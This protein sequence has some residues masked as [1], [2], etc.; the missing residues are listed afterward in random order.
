[1]RKGGGMW[2]L[3]AL[4]AG[5]LAAANS[6]HAAEF[7]DVV[8]LLISS[9]P[10]RG[11]IELVAHLETQGHWQFANR[12]GERF[13][14]S[15]SQEVRR[16]IKA[17][18]PQSDAEVLK[19]AIT[20]TS[21]AVTF[22]GKSLADLPDGA[23]LRAHVDGRTYAL[24]QR[25]NAEPLLQV[26]PAVSLVASDARA[27]SAALWHLNR[28]LP[29]NVMRVVG[30]EPGGP[31]ILSSSPR[32]DP[33]TKQTLVDLLDPG[34]LVPGLAGARGQFVVAKGRVR[35]D[36]LT[37]GGTGRGTGAKEATLSLRE[38][39]ATAAGYDISLIL[40][41]TSSP[42]QPGGRNWLWTPYD[43]QDVHKAGG[44]TARF[45][46]VVSLIAG[47]RPLVVQASMAD[48]RVTLEAKPDAQQGQ[49]AASRWLRS[50][51]DAVT[52]LLGTTPVETIRIS[53]PDVARQRD[54]DRRIMRYLPISVV[55]SYVALLALGLI[56]WP[57]AR[58][59]FAKLWPPEAFAE[60]ANRAGWYAARA[61]RGAVFAL[62][63]IP[64][65]AIVS[66]PVQLIRLVRPT[67]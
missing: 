47:Q 65:A 20:L 45:V 55:W 58:R 11:E 61:V 54:L 59:W 39:V 22:G 24:R 30:F 56:G 51:T 40:L 37:I 14:A 50:L 66:L 1:M 8:G 46:D 18:A 27:M 32:V 48:S 16:A 19:L 25:S 49:S 10:V 44:E 28:T 5:L 38:L 23:S 31:T 43:L 64:L 63:F 6:V 7:D 57:T 13:T 12:A 53:L 29:R 21:T 9:R 15:G 42:A 34:A 4:Q 67:P 17:L 41:E 3:A 2:M 35:G 62:V 60:Y 33:Q 26:T 36:A 52:D